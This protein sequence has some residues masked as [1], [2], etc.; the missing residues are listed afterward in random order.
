[1]KYLLLEIPQNLDIKKNKSSFL[2]NFLEISYFYFSIPEDLS[3]PEQTHLLNIGKFFFECQ[4]STD[5]HQYL[6]TIN[7]KN[8]ILA[9]NSSHQIP[10]EVFYQFQQQII[11]KSNVYDDYFG[12]DI[13]G[14]QGK[15]INFYTGENEDVYQIQF[16]RNSIQKVLNGRTNRASKNISPFFTYLESDYFIPDFPSTED[17]SEDYNMMEFLPA[18]ME[19]KNYPEEIDVIFKKSDDVLTLLNY[20]KELFLQFLKEG[21]EIITVGND[22]CKYS[23]FGINSSDE[24]FGI[25]GEF[26]KNNQTCIFPLSDLKKCLNH[27]NFDQYLQVYRKISKIILPN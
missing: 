10:W 4:T 2:S 15:I 7:D 21:L 12:C 22:H 23:L 19:G 20:W 9:Q 18:I 13:S 17:S 5:I 27:K 1:M 6:R 3:E 11:V 16:S 26:R 14:L 24:A 25:W 8:I